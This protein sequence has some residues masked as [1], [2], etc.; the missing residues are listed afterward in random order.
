M[1][2]DDNDLRFAVMGIRDCFV[3]FR[4]KAAQRLLLAMTDL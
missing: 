2:E 1:F 3:R 4:R